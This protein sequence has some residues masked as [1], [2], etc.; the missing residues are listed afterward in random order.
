MA[1]S[2]AVQE[3]RVM[4]GR[5]QDAIAE[6]IFI[7][8]KTVSAIETG[9]RSNPETLGMVAKALDDPRVWM[10]LAA[11]VTEGAFVPVWLDGQR[12]D[13]HRSTVKAKT[14]EELQEAINALQSLDLIR[15]PDPERESEEERQQR[16]AVKMQLADAFQAIA[17]MLAVFCRDYKESAIETY[18]QH[19]RK[20]QE[21]GHIQPRK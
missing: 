21:Q 3:A 15:T 9:R 4:Q 2:Q 12:V 7:S 10:E 6:A 17:T 8:K 18:R 20:L 11:E 1:I 19:R 5:T 14:I 13:L 16:H